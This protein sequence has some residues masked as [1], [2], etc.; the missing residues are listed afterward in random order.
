MSCNQLD[1]YH[2]VVQVQGWFSTGGLFKQAP[3]L[4][5]TVRQ[6]NTLTDLLQQ[7]EQKPG[8]Y[9]TRLQLQLAGLHLSGW[10]IAYTDGS[11]K[12]VRGWMQASYGQKGDRVF[13]TAA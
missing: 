2:I 1:L 5:T 11:A 12:R 13:V 8:G 4:P 7:K 6:Q 10:T 3:H 9:R